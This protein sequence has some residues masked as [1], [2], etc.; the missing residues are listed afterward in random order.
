M[1][2]V[3]YARVSTTDQD[4]T[5]QIERLTQFGCEKVFRDVA[6]GKLD[7]RPDWDACLAWLR[8]GDT[9]A[10]V[11]LDRFSRST[12]HLIEVADRLQENGQDL[13]TL[14]QP[15]DTRT[16]AGKLFFTILAAFAEFER[17]LISERTVDGLKVARARGRTGGKPGKLRGEKL[18][19]AWAMYDTEKYSVILI[20]QV[21]GVHRNTVYET[22]ERTAGQEM[23]PV[24]AFCFRC[25]ETLA[26][27]P[28]P[29][30]L[31]PPFAEDAEDAERAA[32]RTRARGVSAAQAATAQAATAARREAE[33]ARIASAV[34][35]WEAGQDIAAIAKTVGVSKLQVRNW[36]NA[37]LESAPE[38]QAAS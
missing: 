36:L 21:L 37:A 25:R 28:C 16:A 27:C 29:L 13:V 7:S 17:N 14:D 38:P 35:A 22:F 11:K 1:A 4:L 18:A 15:I 6:S 3:G 24:R 8:P 23:Q 26:D 34:A 31:P 19:W 5:G 33:Q 32:R 10:A 20:G 2:L 12:K 30:P 9:L